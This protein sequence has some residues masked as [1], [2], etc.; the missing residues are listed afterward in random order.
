MGKGGKK[1]GPP[2]LEE[3]PAKYLVIEHPWGMKS[4]KER[5]QRCVDNLGAWVRYMLRHLNDDGDPK[6]DILVEVI[7][8]RS[9]V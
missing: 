7:Y 6:H 5:A 2:Y 1:K 4:G 9:T 8:M 3:P